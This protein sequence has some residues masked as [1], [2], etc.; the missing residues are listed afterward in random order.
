MEE[1]VVTIIC[2]GFGVA[3]GMWLKTVW[4]D[5]GR[6]NY[7]RAVSDLK[8]AR[9]WHPAGSDDAWRVE[10]AERYLAEAKSATGYKLWCWL[11]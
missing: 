4:I 11:N 5:G 2:V 9:R 1:V 3:I 6:Q 8:D 7:D 10:E